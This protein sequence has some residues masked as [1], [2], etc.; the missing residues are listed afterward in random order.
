MATIIYRV[1][2]LSDNRLAT[3]EPGGDQIRS[4][5]E[6]SRRN[7]ARVDVTGALLFNGERFAQVLEGEQ[8]AVQQIFERIQCDPRHDNVRVLQFEPVSERGFD[9]W[10]MAYI[11]KAGREPSGLDD[12]ADAGALDDSRLVGDRVYRLLR[13]HLDKDSVHAD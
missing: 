11:G 7:N 13:E 8:A 2:Y 9:D 1:V 12:I 4:I 5:L 3:E 10:A 6:H